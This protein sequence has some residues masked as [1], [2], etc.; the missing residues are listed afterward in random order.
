MV[1]KLPS[2]CR[3]W[4]LVPYITILGSPVLANHK[5]SLSMDEEA[6]ESA[7][8]NGTLA[9]EFDTSTPSNAC[10]LLLPTQGVERLLITINNLIFNTDTSVIKLFTE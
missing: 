5:L 6:E 8:A 7:V 10:W 2:I 4:A 3:V 1:M 9:L